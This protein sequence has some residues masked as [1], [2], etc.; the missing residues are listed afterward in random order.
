MY[1]MFICLDTLK[2]KIV[3]FKLCT[4]LHFFYNEISENLEVTGIK[5]CWNYKQ[6]LKCKKK[7]VS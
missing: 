5:V 6:K 2:Y 3:S 7:S 4:R 1:F